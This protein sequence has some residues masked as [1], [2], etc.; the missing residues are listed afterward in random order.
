MHINPGQLAGVTM[1]I[2]RENIHTVDAPP[3]P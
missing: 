1:E 2:G 3:H